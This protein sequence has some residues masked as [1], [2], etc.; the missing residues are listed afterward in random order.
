MKNLTWVIL[1]LAVLVVPP[2]IFAKPADEIAS[3]D[4]AGPYEVGFLEY[5]LMDESRDQGSDVF[6]GR[7]IPVALWYPVDPGDTTG[8]ARAQYAFDPYA[9]PVPRVD[10]S[11]FEAEG[12]DP[13][14]EDV[15]LSLDA[16]FPLVVF[17]PGYGATYLFH[18]SVGTRL[19]SH[20]FVVAILSHY[21]DG[22]T[23][24]DTLQHIAMA[25][26]NRTQDI[27]FVLDQLL[28]RNA[29]PSDSFFG[30]VR[31]DQIAAAGW[32]LGGYGVLA[33]TG[34]DDL[35]C[36]TLNFTFFGIPTPA[37]SC[38]PAVPDERIRLIITLEGS[39]QVLH[40]EELSRIEVPA[41]GMGRD[42]DTM[43]A[44]GPL[45]P[46]WQARQHAAIQGHPS[47]RVDLLNSNHMT[48]SDRCIAYPILGDEGLMD[49]GFVQSFVENYCDP[50][51]P[52]AVADPIIMRY[53]LAFLKTELAGE[54]G[55]QKMLT[56]GWAIVHEP[57]IQLFVTEKKNPNAIEEDWPDESTYFPY[58]PGN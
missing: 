32:S 43:A 36:D 34:G 13:A 57:D 50:F 8:A 14:Y 54:G 45:G 4:A 40:F 19:A 29:D 51:I 18:I 53:M 27:P 6:D 7:P 56:P 10:S 28:E 5:T 33:L 9:S 35:V 44:T 23:P 24:T 48:F 15:P 37:E 52:Y 42:W 26:L 58:Q 47:Y 3:L 25:S 16:P 46:D 20:G 21:G 55:Y 2:S 22:A 17:S 30:L 38:V 39:N 41:M 11:L 12:I 1:F 31:P 49:G